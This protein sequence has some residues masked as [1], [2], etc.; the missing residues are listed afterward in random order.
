MTRTLRALRRHTKA[1]L[2]VNLAH[3]L[4]ISSSGASGSEE[5]VHFFKRE[6]LRLREEP[7]DESGADEGQEA[8]E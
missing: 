2:L 1:D 5:D 4:S 6:V 3:A 8:K 7:P